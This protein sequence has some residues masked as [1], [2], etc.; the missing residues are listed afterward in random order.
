MLGKSSN[1][2]TI[3]TSSGTQVYVQLD[4][5]N[6]ICDILPPVTS[7]EIQLLRSALLN[8]VR[9]RQYTT[10]VHNYLFNNL[11]HEL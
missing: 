8:T 5:N 7:K 6:A 2:K 9:G 3:I 10:Q 11:N 4:K 1:Y